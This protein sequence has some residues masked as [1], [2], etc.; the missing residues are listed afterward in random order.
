MADL[1]WRALTVKAR[2]AAL[3]VA[4]FVAA[5]A[6]GFA[7]FVRRHP[8]WTGLACAVF[9]VLLAAF[10]WVGVSLPLSRSLEPLPSPAVVLLDAQGKPFA[11]RGA[12][13]EA[14]VVVA[15]L[16]DYVPNA[17]IAIEDRRFRHHFGLDVW[18][19]G[20]AA[21][22]NLKAGKARE[23]ASTITQQLAKNAFLSNERTLRR[24]AQ[25]AVIA[26]WLELRLSKD[27]ILA[28][29]L[30]SIYFGDGVYGLG[31][32][33]RHYFGRPPEKLTL[34]QAAIL[35]GMVNAPSRL[36]PVDNPKA[37]AARADRVLADMVEVK[38]ITPEQAVAARGARARA[39]RASLPVGGYFAD[40]VSPQIADAFETARYGEVKV[41]TTLDGRLQRRA[42]QAVNRALAKSGGRLKAG[43]AALVAMRP[44]GKVVAMVG[45]RSYAASQFNRA[46]QARRQPGSAFKLFVYLAALRDGAHTD[47]RVVGDPVTIDGW[48]PKNYEGEAGQDMTLRDAFAQSNNII[49]ARIW[50]TAGGEAVVQA[51]RDL[52]ITSPL[53]ATDASLSLG[54][55]ETTLLELTSAYASV[56]SGHMPVAPYGRPRPAGEAAPPSQPL[57]TAQRAALYELLG[58][59]VEEGTGRAA[60][61]GQL[62]Y[63]KTGTTQDHRDALFVG[64]TGDLVVGVWVGNDDH[65]PMNGVTGGG[66]PAQIWRDFVGQGLKAGLIARDRAPVPRAPPPSEDDDL[67]RELSRGIP[68]W[69]RRI[70]GG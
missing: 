36:D 42:E 14:P 37:A 4:A 67:E 16:P 41:P 57:D 19:M 5:K 17:F 43:Q 34:G 12:Y 26:V 6:R 23:G 59:V 45:G 10:V 68:G 20:R 8:R 40:W 69:L 47:M 29:Y 46:V 1:D 58:A 39:V 33:S 51:A 13:K 2:H 7:A 56:A 22:V 38:F 15:D 24:K 60:R 31:A 49:A 63:G 21:A 35:A 66:L 62:T 48:S 54:T 50:Q 11:R 70:F 64:F 55:A 25:E 32:A 30:S 44:D 9:A 53:K 65:S 52:G 3:I 27:E 28:R 61:T 18:G